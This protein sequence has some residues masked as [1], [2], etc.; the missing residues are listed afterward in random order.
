MDRQHHSRPYRC[1]YTEIEI[2]SEKL[3][4]LPGIK[5]AV[6]G[7]GISGIAAVKY[8]L[9]RGAEVF[10]SDIR[11]KE[12]LI[13]DEPGLFLSGSISW[14]TGGHSV[15]FLAQAEIVIVS[16]GISVTSP[17]I[18]ELRIRGV[19]V[20]GELAFAEA[21]IFKPI[22]A[23][24]GT[25]GKTTVTTLIGELLARAGKRVF[26][27]GNI[28]T[29]L[30]DYLCDPEG[31]DVLVLEV[32]SFQLET[33]C[34]FSPHIAVLLNL[35]PD[36]LDRHGSFKKYC[37]AKMKIFCNQK[38]SDAAIINGD[39]SLCRNLPQNILS[40][41]MFFGAG[42]GFEC[43]ITGGD[44]VLCAG[45]E[46]EIYHPESPSLKNRI[47]LYNCAPAIIAAKL[48]GCSGVQ[49]QDVLNTFSS[50]EHR[51]EYVRKVG[52]VSYYNDSKATNTGAV[53]AALNQFEEKVILIAGGRDKGDDY[54]LL[55]RSVSDRVK[56]LVVLGESSDI[57]EEALRGA[58]TIVRAE[59]M[60]DAVQKATGCASEGDVVLLSPACAS[61]D[62][63]TGYAHRGR[64]FKEEVRAL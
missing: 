19:T 37:E 57:I 56:M 27:G 53:A 17:L 20:A 26:I 58:V 2:V 38:N 4:I 1:C 21:L 35:S 42:E 28:G 39:D 45:S 52:G 24:T 13:E 59:S 62:M 12:K 43:R 55:R 3:Q 11:S 9:L 47:G 33:G 50:L 36:H 46:K 29:S 34:D 22:V 49:I 51:M 48:L 7:L 60:K 41:I 32:S 30:F 31:I 5:V 61:F 23:I 14:E 8:A 18:D 64:V 10:V 44:V 6:L 25:N 63:F 40:D 54:R 16:P 15:E